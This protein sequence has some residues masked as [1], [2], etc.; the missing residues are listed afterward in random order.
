MIWKISHI[1]RSNAD[2]NA[3]CQC[4][5]KL[6]FNLVLVLYKSSELKAELH[7]VLTFFKKS[8]GI[9]PKGECILK[10][11]VLWLWNGLSAWPNTIISLSLVREERWKWIVLETDLSSLLSCTAAQVSVQF[12]RFQLIYLKKGGRFWHFCQSYCSCLPRG[13]VT[14]ESFHLWSENDICISLPAKP[15]II[16]SNI[17]FCLFL[18]LLLFLQQTQVFKEK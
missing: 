3:F 8:W 2:W 4:L 12:Q 17:Y 5:D 10:Y 1:I 9:W 11:W 14:W 13:S 7:T 18:Y 6:Y 15:V 16:H